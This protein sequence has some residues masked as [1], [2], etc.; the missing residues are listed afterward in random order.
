MS[1][2]TAKYE[3]GN[4]DRDKL[5]S[6][7]FQCIYHEQF[8]KA[9]KLFN[10]AIE[11]EPDLLTCQARALCET[12][13]LED[14]PNV[15]QVI[16]II[17]NLT[18]SLSLAVEHLEPIPDPDTSNLWTAEKF[19][20]LISE[21][22]H[23]EFY[24]SK[25]QIKRLSELGADLMNFADKEKKNWKLSYRFRKL[26]FAF[27]FRGSPIFGVNLQSYQPRLCIWLPEDIIIDREDDLKLEDPL[28]PKHE[29]YYDWFHS[30]GFAAYSTD[31]EVAALEP[32]LIFA[33]SYRIDQ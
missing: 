31:V 7:G 16:K 21:Q 8:E 9:I 13:L 14:N 30:T 27:Y 18:E 15:S 3:T 5:I 22:E 25:G 17:A 32:L 23:K 6:D 10:Q 11:I 26:Y 1:Q 24:N 12:F 29:R 19:K 20:E 28:A 33:C 2:T 4:L